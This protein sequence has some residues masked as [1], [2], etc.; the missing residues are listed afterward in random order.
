M[1]SHRSVNIRPV[2]AQRIA[3]SAGQN[4]TI[5]PFRIY[6]E[7]DLAAERACWLKMIDASVSC[8]QHRCYAYA[9]KRDDLTPSLRSSCWEQADGISQRGALGWP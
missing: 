2:D 3:L 5:T 4:G 8:C 1:R 9:R 7:D 6:V